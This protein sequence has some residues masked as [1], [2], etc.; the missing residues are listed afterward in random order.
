MSVE[1]HARSTI[2]YFV[3]SSGLLREAT[4][5]EIDGELHDSEGNP[6]IAT[7]KYQVLRGWRFDRARTYTSA[8]GVNQYLVKA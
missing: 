5:L 6:L 4:L 7:D 8:A 1:V 3:E 2:A